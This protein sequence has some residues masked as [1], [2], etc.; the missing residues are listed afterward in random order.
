VRINV[1]SNSPFTC[2]L[3]LSLQDGMLLP[4]QHWDPLLV[5]DA[6]A[7]D[8][9]RYDCVCTWIH[10][11]HL[12]RSVAPRQLQIIGQ[13]A[14]PKPGSSFSQLHFLFEKSC[15]GVNKLGSVEYASQFSL[16]LGGL[17]PST[18]HAV[19]IHSLS[20]PPLSPTESLVSL[21]TAGT[22]VFVLFVL[23]SVMVKCFVID[24]V[25]LS[26]RL[27]PFR[28]GDTGVKVFDAY[29]VYQMPSHEKPIEELL[30]RF[31]SQELPHILENM[32]GYKLF[33]HGRDNL[34]GED[35]V[36]LVEERMRKSRRLMVILTPCA[37]SGVTE[38]YEQPEGYDWQVG[39]H[40]ALVLRDLSVILIQLGDTGP[41]G[42]SHL[43]PALQH[44]IQKS[45]PIRWTPGP[46][47]AQVHS[48]FWKRVRY[49]MPATPVRTYPLSTI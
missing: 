25:L 48:R 20:T 12:Y 37:A 5:S 38:T 40:Q 30:C 11:N 21:V 16:C 17:S 3:T 27:F 4:E 7:K 43:P 31:V 47:T 9:G 24:L 36:E 22:C 18:K 49:L 35:L 2:E 1:F 10:Q 15:L 41:R 44:L 26:R 14:V 6:T 28:L 42:Y 19:G 8:Q 13:S 39:L 32:C 34:P 46:C 33:I 29:V 45:A 23:I